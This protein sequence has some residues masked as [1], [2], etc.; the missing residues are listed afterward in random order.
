MHSKTW[1]IVFKISER[2]IWNA[3][4]CY[5]FFSGDDTWKLHPRL[6]L[7]QVVEDLGKACGACGA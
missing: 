4:H 7:R 6:F 2:K 3:T 1:N 5:F